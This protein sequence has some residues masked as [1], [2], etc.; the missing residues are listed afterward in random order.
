MPPEAIT[1]T[2]SGANRVAFRCS[3][4]RAFLRKSI[5]AAIGPCRVTRPSRVANASCSAVMSLKPTSTL[6]PAARIASQSRRSAMR[7]T[8]YPP[9]AHSTASTDGSHQAVWS[10]RPGRRRCPRGSRRRR[11]GPGRAGH[12]RVEVPARS[13]SSPACRRSSGTG[14][15]GATTA[16]RAPGRAGRAGQG[17]HR[18]SSK[19]GTPGGFSPKTWEYRESSASRRA[20]WSRPPEAVPL[21]LEGE[22]GVRHPAAGDAFEEPLALRGR[23]DH[24]VQSLEQQEGRGDPVGAAGGGPLG[25]AVGDLGVGADQALQV[26]RLEVVG[27]A[28]GPAGE[29]EDR[30]DDGA[31]GVHVGGGQGGGGRPAPALPRARPG[32]PGRRCLVGEGEATAAQSS[33]STTPHCS[34]SRRGTPGRTGG[35]A[36]VD[37][38]DADAAGGEVGDLQVQDEGRAAGGAAVRPDHVRRQLAVRGAEAGVVRRVHVRVDLASARAGEGAAARRG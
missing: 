17:L 12:H 28:R 34:R 7:W 8:P 16:T 11:A 15:L 27:A 31:A 13:T 2:V 32:A 20:P 29:V 38:G 18:V 14:P 37:L 24:V 10:R 21:A 26:L 36:V 5:P 9:R 23:A 30:V 35:A 6:G 4:A 33:T 1:R 25:V 19:V 3:C 22:V